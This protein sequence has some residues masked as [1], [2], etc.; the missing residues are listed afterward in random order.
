MSITSATFML[1]EGDQQTVL[2]LLILT[3][4]FKDA[5]LFLWFGAHHCMLQFLQLYIDDNLAEL[6]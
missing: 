3:K 5:S 1:F 2:Q 4:Q 6:L